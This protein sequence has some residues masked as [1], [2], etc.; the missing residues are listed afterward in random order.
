MKLVSS[1][2]TEPKQ[3]FVLKLD[4][5][6]SVIIR[7]YYYSS[8][9]SWY[10][11]IE[12]NEYINNGNKVVLTMNALRHLRNIIPFG[13]AFISGSNAEPFQLED[14]A[15]GNVLMLLLNQN[16]VQEIE[17]TVYNG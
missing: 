12:Y 3:R 8:Q 2:T 16:D 11:D 5:N 4:N 9:N 15:N 1:I 6:E 13:I 7:L 17:E 10:F 14:F